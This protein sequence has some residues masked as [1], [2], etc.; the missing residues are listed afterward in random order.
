MVDII[1]LMLTKNPTLD[2]CSTDNHPVLLDHIHE[3]PVSPFALLRVEIHTADFLV[4]RMI[5]VLHSRDSVLRPASGMVRVFPDPP[6]QS[7]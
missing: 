5:K 1:W 6:Y 7:E 4:P 2:S 3:P